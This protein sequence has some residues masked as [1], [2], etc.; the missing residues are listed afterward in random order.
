[1]C[2]DTVGQNRRGI[3]TIACFLCACRRFHDATRQV[4]F[5]SRTPGNVKIIV[6]VHIRGRFVFETLSPAWWCRVAI[7]GDSRDTT[8]VLVTL[9]HAPCRSPLVVQ[10]NTRSVSLQ[11]V[12]TDG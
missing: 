12:V 8:N 5:R 4:H 11:V 10:V 3:P 7:S 2:F 9:R 6:Q 1:M